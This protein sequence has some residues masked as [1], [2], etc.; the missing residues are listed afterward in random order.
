MTQERR[1]ARLR[2]IKLYELSLVDAPANPHAR[3]TLFKRDVRT[4][5]EETMLQKNEPLGF[6]TLDDAVEHLQNTLKCGRTQ[7]MS[8]AA[9]RFPTLVA[10][11]NDEGREIAR[12]AA[13]DLA[14]SRTRPGAVEDFE[15]CVDEVAKR[16]GCTRTAAMRRAAEEYPGAFAAYRSA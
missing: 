7:A 10:K 4:E 5:K 1:P 13:E 11:F 16:D 2:A 12:R 9:E 14:K 6:D 8:R 15:R 3:V